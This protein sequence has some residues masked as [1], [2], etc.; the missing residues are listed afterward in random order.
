[1]YKE[2]KTNKKRRKEKKRNRIKL[3]Y[4]IEEETK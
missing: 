4:E 2:K 3:F 1:M